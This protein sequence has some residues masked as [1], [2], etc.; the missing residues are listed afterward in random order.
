MN[1]TTTAQTILAVPL[2]KIHESPTNSRRTWGNLEEL[3]TSIASVGVL[4]PGL[5]RPH[6]SKGDHFE[7]VFGHRRLR[8]SALAKST[9][10]PLIVRHL[11][12]EQ[13]I[14]IQAIEN[15]QRTD[16]HELE[17]AE[18]YEQLVKLGWSAE[19]IAEK[20]GKSR[21]YVFGRLK[22]L[23]LSAKLREAFYKGR[24]GFS[25][26]LYLA[27]LPN[28]DLQAQAWKRLDFRDGDPVSARHAFDVID[29][30]FMCRLSEAKWD[31]KEAALVPQAGACTECPKR[32]GNQRELFGDVKSA[33]VC[34]DPSCFQAKKA[35]DNK[36]RLALFVEKGAEVLVGKE[37]EKLF[38]G[39]Y[40]L[41][42][43]APFV[44]LGAANY[45]D[46]KHRTWRA[47]LKGEDLALTVAVDAKGELHEL[48]PRSAVAK[49]VKS[50]RKDSGLDKEDAKRRADAKRKRIRTLAVLEVVVAK[51]E[52]KEPGKGSGFWHLM[53]AL[54]HRAAGADS[55]LEIAKR[56]GLA[57]E[58]T[59]N[60]SAYIEHGKAIVKALKAMGEAEARGL[61]LE[62]AASA[63]GFSFGPYSGK[64]LGAGLVAAAKFYRVDVA[65][66]G[67][68]ALEARKKAK[69]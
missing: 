39:G 42:H 55:H 40:G 64:E 1:A 18:G 49:L 6:P 60:R 3:A 53:A 26:A 44:E 22:L 13:A 54:L 28:E 50:A 9:S 2:A 7:L 24:F 67:A 11:T 43:T 5:A 15:L 47:L 62:Y 31:K 27:R 17:E 19:T 29:R 63:G 10:M 32:T 35:A 56:R 12:D 16:L 23:A 14:E 20:I 8:A 33:D 51:A 30:E 34:T 4:E 61:A 52:A 59:A 45:E 46:P 21:S 37:A 38:P 25:V 58:K 41:S 48:V 65:K 36:R 69:N 57:G 66:I 68:A